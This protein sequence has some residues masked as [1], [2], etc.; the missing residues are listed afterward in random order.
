MSLLR[1][2]GFENF[3]ATFVVNFVPTGRARIFHRLPKAARH[4]VP[5]LAGQTRFHS[6]S[7]NVWSRLQVATPSRLKPGL[8]AL[9]KPGRGQT[10]STLPRLLSLS[11]FS[12]GLSNINTL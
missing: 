9:H 4:G 7:R 10:I 3:V 8:H 1:K 2:S 11:R 5:A 6:E 12:Y